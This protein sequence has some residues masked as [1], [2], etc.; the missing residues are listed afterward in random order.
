MQRACMRN[1]VQMTGT[2]GRTLF[3]IGSRLDGGEYERIELSLDHRK[4]GAD[5]LFG[6]QLCA[7]TQS[8]N[9]KIYALAHLLGQRCTRQDR[10]TEF[11]RQDR[12][13]DLAQIVSHLLQFIFRPHL[14]LFSHFLLDR[15][16]VD[17]R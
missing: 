5:E 2:G 11:A 1:L 12:L 3:T 6:I 10:Q 8:R 15:M 9:A 13:V 17:L 14:I 4:D 16:P 7:I